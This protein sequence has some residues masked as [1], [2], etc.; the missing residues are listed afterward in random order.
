[1]QGGQFVV[2]ILK[3]TFGFVAALV[4][5][6]LFLAWGLFQSSGPGDDVVAF[7]A[8]VGTGMVTASVI[9]AVAMAPAFIAILI[10]EVLSL[11]GAIYHVGAAGVIALAIWMFDPQASG[12]GL[13]PG[14]TIV[15][16][17][18]FMAGIIYWLIA[19]RTS[20][21]WRDAGPQAN[22]AEGQS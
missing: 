21:C 16:A 11:K 9:G 2:Q 3:I 1:M 6:G 22:D 4:T 12:A 20:G 19:G 18:G 17:A 5:A 14:T 10:A 13:R 15:L 8:M 7:A